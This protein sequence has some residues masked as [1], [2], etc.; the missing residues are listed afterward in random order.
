MF[1]K[2]NGDEIASGL[3]MAPF[4]AIGR[5]LGKGDEW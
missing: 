4:V 2:E 1:M 3:P 5:L